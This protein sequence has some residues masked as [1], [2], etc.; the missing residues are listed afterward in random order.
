MRFCVSPSFLFFLWYSHFE[1]LQSI[2]HVVPL[3]NTWSTCNLSILCQVNPYE[4]TA[5]WW[6]LLICNLWWTQPVLR[7][8]TTSYIWCGLQ[9]M[10]LISSISSMIIVM[11]WTIITVFNVWWSWMELN[12]AFIFFERVL[13]T[14]I[15]TI[16]WLYSMKWWFLYLLFHHR[17]LFHVVPFSFFSDA[18]VGVI[19]L[20]RDL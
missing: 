5:A 16:E 1:S 11:I 19:F 18:A 6:L 13:L 12:Y 7:C 3:T 10:K 14:G 20:F 17:F 15:S 4:L 8:M 9:F 2:N